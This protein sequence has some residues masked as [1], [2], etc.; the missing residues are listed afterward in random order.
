MEPNYFPH[1]PLPAK[2]AIAI[3]VA[4]TLIIGLLDF[5]TGYGF[6]LSVFYLVPIAIATW[7][8]GISAGLITS[9]AASLLWL[10]SFQTANFYNNQAYFFW[11]AGVM[12]FGFAADTWLVSR[13]RNA[14]SRADA[15]FMT[16]VE[17]M[18]VAISVSSHSRELLCA[19]GEMTQLVG[20]DPDQIDRFLRRLEVIEP[21]HE[22]LP[23]RFKLAVVRD[24]IQN[25]WYMMHR[26]DIPWSSSSNAT[27][28]VLT[29]ITEKYQADALRAKNREISHHVARLTILSE[30]AS[31]L[32]HEINQPLM[33]ITTY[34]DACRRLLDQSTEVK[35]EIHNAIDRC[36]QQAVRAAA[37]VAR[38]NDF[39]RE[40]R[41]TGSPGIL[42]RVLDDVIALSAEDCR[43][44][45]V[46]VQKPSLANMTIAVDMDHILLT[47]ILHNLIRNAIDAMIDMPDDVR[48]IDIDIA[49]SVPSP[50]EMTI[51]ISDRGHGHD[52]ET[53]DRI[54]EPFFTTREQGLGLG[55]SICKSIAEAHEG[56]L[57]AECNHRGGLTFKLTLPIS[58]SPLAHVG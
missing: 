17:E 45:G 22:H 6:R 48:L 50:Q 53:L 2:S 14:V 55:L 13:L 15:R 12:L 20:G 46:H 27:L 8:R 38:L 21:T 40:K 18:P 32:A 47:Q 52:P 26:G 44:H 4:L 49:I 29:D 7:V 30:V 33:A 31:T 9:C 10:L 42:Q 25:H 43:H 37:V 56:S 3:A 54:F 11:E 24:P 34:T 35:P 39:I 5:A 19:N 57:S 36:H 28:N 51:R 16:I 41:P 58:Q 1:F 23:N